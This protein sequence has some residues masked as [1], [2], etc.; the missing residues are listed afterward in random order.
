MPPK[1]IATI[2]RYL[3]T[4]VFYAEFFKFFQIFSNFCFYFFFF[5]FFFFS[6]HCSAVYI[7]PQTLL[8]ATLNICCSKWCPYT[9]ISLRRHCPRCGMSFEKCHSLLFSA[10]VCL[11]YLFPSTFFHTN[12]LNFHLC[13]SDEAEMSANSLLKEQIC[14]YKCILLSRMCVCV[15]VHIFRIIFK[16][17]TAA[18][19]IFCHCTTV[20]IICKNLRINHM[21]K[22]EKG[23][24]KWT[25]MELKC[26]VVA[27]C[28]HS[29]K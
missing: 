20:R 17:S 3:K 10:I 1:C 29:V 13:C 28:T 8:C 11:T 18:S 19:Y 9:A 22:M 5:G 12:I 24:D 25:W 4:F 26:N 7:F 6:F 21:H 2:L 14:K 16:M 27:S 15:R 23:H